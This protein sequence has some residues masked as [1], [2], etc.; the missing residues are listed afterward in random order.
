ME[1]PCALVWFREDLRLEDNP[2]LQ[3]A[4]A[5]EYAVVPVF[6]E[7]PE[8]EGD[9]P[10]GGASKWFRHGALESLASRLAERGGRLLC[11]R[12]SSAERKLRELV[13]QTGARAVFWNRC[14]PRALRERDQSI[15]KAL[16]AEGLDVRSFNS[17]LLY[18]P[19]TVEQ[20]NGTGFTVYSRF[21]K[22]VQD[23]PIDPPV[24]TDLD[25]IR[26]PKKWPSDDGVDGLGLLP[27]VR[28]DRKLEPSWDRSEAAAHRLLSAFNDRA[29]RTY[30]KQ[31]N[32][33]DLPA[34]SELSPY[35]HHGLISPRQI[36]AVVGA[37]AEASSKGA[38]K[39]LDEVRWREFAYHLLYHYPHLPDAS[40]QEE[41]RDF[42]WEPDETV[43]RAWQRGET[44]Y[45]V[46]DAAMRGLWE[47][48]WMHNRT[49]MT[50]ASFLTK[51]LLQPWTAGER[52][53]WDTL[54]DADLA[55][56]GLGWQ[57]SAGGG[58]DG[59]SYP[60][61]FNPILQGR[62]FD[63]QGDYVRRFL[64]ELARLP[65]EFLH[66]PWEAPLLV[67]QEA[68]VELGKTYPHPLVDHSTARRKALAA[69]DALPLAG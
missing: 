25:A 32:R 24:V 13:E 1:T 57:W 15:K 52:W 14:Y 65:T 39:F 51:H 58:A 36:H 20:P 68:G 47:T 37:N 54:V 56:N 69:F 21:R 40:L 55:S 4:I 41:F 12:T 26:F 43:L 53:F 29:L 62:K 30:D 35:L 60:R 28:W 59:A 2:A 31:R 46:V 42:P 61:I 38:W 16:K 50:V 45:P 67:L 66:A 27:G 19:H 8:E 23:R 64:P 33:P 18:E 34:T 9:W 63:P 6:L 3:A 17:A 5:A 22:F 7:S 48:G 49:R 10:T 11:F 44:G